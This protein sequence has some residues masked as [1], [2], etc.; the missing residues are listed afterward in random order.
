MSKVPTNTQ[1]HFSSAFFRGRGPDLIVWNSRSWWGFLICSSVIFDPRTFFF[2]LAGRISSL[3]NIE[4][5][6]GQ[7]I[8][9]HPY[10][11]PWEG[12]PQRNSKRQNQAYLAGTLPQGRYCGLSRWWLGEW[13]HNSW[14]FVI[15][16]FI[17][18]SNKH[19][20]LQGLLNGSLIADVVM[21]A[22]KKDCRIRTKRFVNDPERYPA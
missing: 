5:I 4:F 6:R 10:G 13:G 19:E 7:G 14:V 16:F 18:I 20:N 17:K 22:L 11:A 9:I 8:Y 2:H 15:E 21:N 1:K 12:F 3:K